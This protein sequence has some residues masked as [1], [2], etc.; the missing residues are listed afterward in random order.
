M[1]ITMIMMMIMIMII[2][3]IIIIIITYPIGLIH[4]TRYLCT[5]LRTYGIKA[6]SRGFSS[7]KQV[8]KSA[9]TRNRGRFCLFLLDKRK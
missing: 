3:I 7:G 8:I 2:I 5:R 4:D 6:M 1:I 9:N